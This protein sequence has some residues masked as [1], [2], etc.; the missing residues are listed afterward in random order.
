MS[1]V[2]EDDQSE[3]ISFWLEGCYMSGAAGHGLYAAPK[4]PEPP[5]TGDAVAGRFYIHG[6]SGGRYMCMGVGYNS[7]NAPQEDGRV[8]VYYRGPSGLMHNR[9]LSEWSQPVEWPDGVIR[10]RFW[11]AL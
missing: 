6:K 8:E 7:N 10:P 2:G 5:Q 4:Q 1:E 11:P 9:A 3:E